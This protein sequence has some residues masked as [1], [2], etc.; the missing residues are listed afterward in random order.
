MRTAV[1]VLIAGIIPAAAGAGGVNTGVFCSVDRE[2]AGLM[3]AWTALE[4]GSYGSIEASAALLR[5][6][7]ALAMALESPRDNLPGD[8]EV[9][10]TDYLKASADC[11][12]T[13]RTAV[14]GHNGDGTAERLRTSFMRWNDAGM[15]FMD[16]VLST[17]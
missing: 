7:S 3:D 16:S 4:S 2:I 10:W 12:F 1:M 17:R 11:I 15:E 6:E 14:S 5:A 9:K 13:F 8:A